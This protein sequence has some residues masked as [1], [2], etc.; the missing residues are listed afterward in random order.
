M[1]ALTA[2]L[3]AFPHSQILFLSRWGPNSFSEYKRNVDRLLHTVDHLLSPQCLFIWRGALPVAPQALGS[4]LFYTDEDDIDHFRLPSMLYDLLP[5]DVHVSIQMAAHNHPFVQ[6]YTQFRELTQYRKWDGLHWGSIGHRMITQAV[7]RMVKKAMFDMPEEDITDEC[8]FYNHRL[9]N[10]PVRK[11]PY[12]QDYGDRYVLHSSSNMYDDVRFE[13]ECFEDNFV[14]FAEQM[15]SRWVTAPSLAE[16]PKSPAAQKTNKPRSTGAI[17]SVSQNTNVNHHAKGSPSLPDHNGM[18]TPPKQDVKKTSQPEELTTALETSAGT[19]EL[20]PAAQKVMPVVLGPCSEDQE[21][22]LDA[23]EASPATQKDPC[24]APKLKPAT[25]NPSLHVQKPSCSQGPS[26]GVPKVS[27]TIQRPVPAPQKPK[28]LDLKPGLV[29]QVTK[30]QRPNQKASAIAQKPCQAA[31][32]SSPSV[33]KLNQAARKIIVAARKVVVAAQKSEPVPKDS[34]STAQKSSSAAAIS[35][36]AQKHGLIAPKPS[37]VNKEVGAVPQEPRMSTSSQPEVTVKSKS[38]V[39]AILSEKKVNV[40]GTNSKCK[41]LG[42]QTGEVSAVDRKLKSGSQNTLKRKNP[43]DENVSSAG[44]SNKR[45]RRAHTYNVTFSPAVPG[46][47]HQ[48]PWH[49]RPHRPQSRPPFY[50]SSPI[51]SRY[52]YTN[53]QNGFQ[54]FRSSYWDSRY[55]ND[56][57]SGFYSNF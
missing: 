44:R 13:N 27:S 28:L 20:T 16:K 15:K 46:T 2:L 29:T 52:G 12:M 50:D 1:Q 35:G 23:A 37:P 26:Q 48:R 9:Y 31:Q 57:P 21:P 5:A 25:E 7:I 51:A 6:L 17:A 47:S 3:T 42:G 54:G 32:N 38:A 22:C 53:P 39:K 14:S 33:G 11:P 24:P 41:S 40:V 10:G 30:A 34:S 8:Q 56:I 19:Q 49:P 18:M 36:T 4:S 45:H 55:G 43:S